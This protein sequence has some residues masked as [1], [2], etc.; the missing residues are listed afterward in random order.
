GKTLL[1]VGLGGI[2]T[3]V[4]RRAHGIGMTVVATR[5][6]GTGGPDFVSHIGEP[7]ELGALARAA[8][9]IV[10]CVPLTP[11]TTKLYDTRF[12]VLV[13]PTA[14]F[15]NV[16]RGASVDAD[17]LVRALEEHRPAG[18]GLDVTEPEPLPADH[19]L[20][21]APRVLITPH[22]SSRSDL[23]DQTRWTLARE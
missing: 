15:M 21:R 12:F 19:P 22:T 10:N 8:D 4:A 16:A 2:G 14:L 9:V 17:A 3:E 5:A 18:A 7:G 1:V 23:N 6:G 13:K 11:E 20:W